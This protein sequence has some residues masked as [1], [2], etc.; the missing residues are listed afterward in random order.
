M[1]GYRY[2]PRYKCLKFLGEY[3]SKYYLMVMRV[4][5]KYRLDALYIACQVYYYTNVH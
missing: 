5:F 1:G 4:M 2:Y 3:I